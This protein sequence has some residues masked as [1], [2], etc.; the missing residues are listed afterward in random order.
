MNRESKE[1]YEQTT[2]NQVYRLSTKVV[3]WNIGFIGRIYRNGVIKKIFIQQ[4]Q[5]ED[6]EE[7]ESVD[8]N[9]K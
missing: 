6:Q 1:Y 2:I 8:S 4:Q 3:E 7:T 5:E 9:D